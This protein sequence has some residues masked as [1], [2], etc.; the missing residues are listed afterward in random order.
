MDL[1]EYFQ[2]WKLLE[3]LQGSYAPHGNRSGGSQWTY[4][5]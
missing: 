1:I 2:E 3:S 5:R 4:W